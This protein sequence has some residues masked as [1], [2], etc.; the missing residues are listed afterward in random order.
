MPRRREAQP[1]STYI[2]PLST[3]CTPSP[4]TSSGRP[5]VKAP[6]PSKAARPLNF[7]RHCCS[8]FSHSISS[9]C[10]SLFKS[11][12]ARSFF[13][14]KGFDSFHSMAEALCTG[15]AAAETVVPMAGAPPGPPSQA[16]GWRLRTG[17]R[18]RCL[19]PRKPA[20]QDRWVFE[21]FQIHFFLVSHARKEKEYQVFTCVWL[22]D[23][24]DG[25]QGHEV[26]GEGVAAQHAGGRVRA[27]PRRLP[28]RRR[29]VVVDF[30]SPGCGGCRALHPKACSQPA[31]DKIRIYIV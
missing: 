1:A 17:S 25:L 6:L 21:S 22:A 28:A 27:G 19:G 8:L 31:T 14:S 29:L 9:S 12:L 5:E 3:Y 4:S 26:V 11:S 18:G 7:R 2:H 10:C 23:E 13:S 20:R 15:G 30:F 24:P 16:G